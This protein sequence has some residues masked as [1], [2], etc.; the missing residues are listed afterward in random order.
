[1]STGVKDAETSISSIPFFFFFKNISITYFVIPYLSCIVT[2]L[3]Y[4]DTLWD[5][6]VCCQRRVQIMS[7]LKPL[8]HCF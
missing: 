7:L 3:E 8:H 5:L 4:S 6:F 2:P 1:M